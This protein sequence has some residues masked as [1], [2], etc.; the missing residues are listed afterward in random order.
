MSKSG[1][2]EVPSGHFG[3]YRIKRRLG[4]GGMSEV[5][6]AEAVDKH[7][8]QVKV[9]LKM[10]KKGID[11]SFFA[12]EADLMGLLS[13]PNLVRM[14]EVGQA[15]GRYYIAMEFLV[16]GDL[17]EVMEAHQKQMSGVP[18]EIAVHVVI[19]LLKGLAYFHKATTRTGTAL[20]LVHSDVNP[21]NIFF[22]GE[23]DVKL[24][25]FGVAATAATLAQGVAAG[26]LSY[27]SPEQTRGETVTA[28][29]DLWAAGVTLYELVVGYHPF[30]SEGAS[31]QQVMQAI[32]AAKL[33]IPDY[34]AKPVAAVLQK[35]LAPEQKNRFKTAGEF[36]GPLFTWALDSGK[37]PS[38]A[39][40]AE[41]LSHA[42]GL[43][44]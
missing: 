4:E 22:S 34:V 39:Q 42:L 25:D 12:Q 20:N 9:A 14:L 3:T 36:A 5:F 10:M 15:Y 16:G 43:V 33:S 37:A 11:E 6:L 21:A 31:E 26:K 19:E 27:L 40:V 13:H 30:R 41:W 8:D 1:A 18:Q 44:V 28:A 17:R 24:G 7:G 35:A 2:I 29:A 32:R 23:G 38:K